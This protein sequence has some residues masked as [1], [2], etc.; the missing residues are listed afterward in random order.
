MSRVGKQPVTIPE[1]VKVNITANEIEFLG[2]KGKLFSPLLPQ[3]K[4]ELKDNQLVF[5]RTA[6]TAAP[7]GDPRG[8]TR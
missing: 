5:T 2:P 4:V 6:E 8:E 1:G 7:R 3:V